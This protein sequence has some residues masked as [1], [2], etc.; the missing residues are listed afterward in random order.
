M[1]TKVYLPGER[2]SRRGFLQKGL[3]GGA[4]LAAGGLGWLAL[5]PS[6]DEPLPAGGLTVLAPV[7][8]A[9]LTAVAR[10]ML[11][12]REGYPTLKQ[13]DVGAACDVILTK[14]DDTARRETRQ[15]LNVFENAA[16]GLLFGLRT[17]PFTRLPP[18]EQDAVLREWRDSRLLIRRTG[19]LALRSLVMAGYFASKDVWPA[20]GYP[21]PPPGVWDPSAPVWKGGGAPRPPGNGV[22]VEVAP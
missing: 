2:E 19:Y 14:V 1:R 9:V 16:L 15:L 13:L 12:P 5:R 11:P 4:V 6:L 7:E 20:L 22:Y 3:I 18:D 10:R 21:G 8:Y 17:R